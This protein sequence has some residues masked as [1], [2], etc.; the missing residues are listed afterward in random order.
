MAKCLGV[1]PNVR[2][3]GQ[4]IP[5]SKR[6]AAREALYVSR[7]LPRKRVSRTGLGHY[8]LPSL[9]TAGDSEAS[10]RLRGTA[11]PGAS[12]DPQEP[13]MVQD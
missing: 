13:L 9:E 3:P 8:S 7:A 5:R 10:L 1:K 6:V 4:N 12:Q 2:G 11:G